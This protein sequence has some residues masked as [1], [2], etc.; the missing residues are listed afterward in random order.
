MLAAPS[1]QLAS[2]LDRCLLV[3]ELELKA[4]QFQML[5]QPLPSLK[6]APN[7]NA[8]WA[9]A[10]VEELCRH[11]IY[12]FGVAPGITSTMQPCMLPPFC[13]VYPAK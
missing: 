1:E 11:G 13:L 7:V 12:T 6:D 9:G 3:Q 2:C 10:L 4:R 5:L 8:L